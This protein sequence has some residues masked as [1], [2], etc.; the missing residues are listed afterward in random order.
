[1]KDNNTIEPINDQLPIYGVESIATMAIAL[2]R[3]YDIPID[4]S[5]LVISEHN[6]VANSLHLHD[7][8]EFK[9]SEPCKLNQK[10]KEAGIGTG[11]KRNSLKIQKIG[12]NNKSGCV[13]VAWNKNSR[14]WVAYIT[15]LGKQYHLMTT[16]SWWDAVC[17]RKSAEHEY[18]FHS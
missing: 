4:Q 6:K 15:K 1:M 3:K 7:N 16:N 10:E 17:A 8:S 2:S 11:T 18:G 13:G 14:K 5:I 12:S 9:E